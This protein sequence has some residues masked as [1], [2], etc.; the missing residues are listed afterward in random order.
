MLSLIKLPL[1][2]YP[3]NKSQE[4]SKQEMSYSQKPP[5][6]E[7]Y[8]VTHALPGQVGFSIPRI[9][10]DGEYLKRLQ[11]LLADE[12][13]VLS[14]QINKTAGSIV[15]TYNKEVMSDLEMRSHLAKLIQ[16]ASFEETRGQGDRETGGQG[17]KGE[18]RVSS[19]SH[20]PTR[21]QGINQP[22]KVAYS[23]AHAIPGR[24]RFRVPRIAEDPKYVKSLEALLKAEP[25]VTSE[26]V[27]RAA[28]SIIITYKTEA[29]LSSQK[30]RQN[31]L[32]ITVS[33]LASLI[34]SAYNTALA[35]S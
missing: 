18:R 1:A 15:I 23:I 10:E 9:V 29:M 8:S 19:L 3:G 7:F 17:D 21:L 31:V 30:S 25:T 4:R 34:Q 13:W 26:R 22:A 5:V 27:N 14:E 28:A 32:Q 12:P 2:A 6:N 16:F 35:I 24:V 20:S 33:H 11:A